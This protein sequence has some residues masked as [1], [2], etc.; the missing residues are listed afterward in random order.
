MPFQT[1]VGGK[2]GGCIGTRGRV[3]ETTTDSGTRSAKPGDGIYVPGLLHRHRL[4]A[5]GLSAH[6]QGRGGGRGR[7]KRRGLR[8]RSGGQPPIAA[9]TSQVRYIPGAS[10]ATS[11]YPQGRLGD[12]NPAA[13]HSDLRG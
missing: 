13:G 7:T 6:T 11:P 3:H 1:T 2:H 9:G 8:G 4:A 10:G 12:R 5:G